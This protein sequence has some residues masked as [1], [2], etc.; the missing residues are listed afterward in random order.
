MAEFW[1]P[2]VSARLLGMASTRLVSAACSG[3]RSA[4]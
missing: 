1:N 3:Q 4:A 2:A